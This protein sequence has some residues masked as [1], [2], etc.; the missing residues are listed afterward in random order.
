MM[1]PLDWRAI[2]TQDAFRCAIAGRCQWN[3][4]PS[5]AV[6]VRV[7]SYVILLA[8]PLIISAIFPAVEQTP[9][10]W[11]ELLADEFGLLGFAIL[12]LQFVIAARLPWLERPFGLDR[13]FRFHRAA[14]MVAASLLIVH[15]TLMVANGEFDLV[16]K[17]N[18]AWPVQLGR[19]A[20][21]AL[22]AL[23]VTSAAWRAMR[24]P[25]ESWRRLHNALA[26][27]LLTLAAAHSLLA[28]DDLKMWPMRAV[29]G[30]LALAA[31]AAYTYH[32]RLWRMRREALYEV[33]EIT[34]EARDAWT[35]LLKPAAG[36]VFPY[37]P[38]QFHFIT[39]HHA[40]TPSEEHPFT[41]S[42]SPAERGAV[43]S[44]IKASGDFTAR[45]GEVRVGDR[46]WVRGPFGRF[47]HL[48]HPRARRLV[49]IAGGVGITPFMSMLRYMR[50]S[51]EWRPTALLYANKAEV[52]ILFRTELQAL[53]AGSRGQL[54]V[55]HIL[56]R[57]DTV[58]PGERGRL[59]V[60]RLERYATPSCRD[61]HI[62]LCG[63]PPMIRSTLALLH[64]MGVSDARIHCELFAL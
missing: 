41:I 58:W 43:A 59:D 9:R 11:L 18:V 60:D 29:W 44:T 42:S 34:Q 27:G 30:A 35:L 46:A 8:L 64:T 62:Y 22:L 61:A 54:Q 17:L 55:M 2:A 20:L 10:T 6:A 38:G 5:R 45:I 32:K 36:I 15:P 24:M 16:R 47:S 37:L 14:A 26:L 56:S 25:F 21:L 39:L 28:G 49:F 31:L 19:L 23:V 51:A 63:P 33:S 57:P 53:Q 4:A 48:L 7:L 52:D 40:G 1:P 50:D 3:R 13:V 12:C